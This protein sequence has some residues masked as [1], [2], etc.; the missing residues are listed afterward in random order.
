MKNRTRETCTSGSV[1]DGGGNIL[2]HS[3]NE[4]GIEETPASFEARSA[5]R[6][7]PTTKARLSVALLVC[8][9]PLGPSLRC[10]PSSSR[11][12]KLQPDRLVRHLIDEHFTACRYLL[13]PH[14][15]VWSR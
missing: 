14:V 15:A 11:R 3:E 10:P 9:M 8:R 2:I 6:S 1:R 4:R 7:Y 12:S 5:P 13:D